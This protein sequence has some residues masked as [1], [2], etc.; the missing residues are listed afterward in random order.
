MGYQL[1]VYQFSRPKVERGDFSHFIRLY[2]PDKLPSGRALRQMMN[3]L[4]FMIEGFDSD[5][6]ELHSIPEVR[7]FYAAFRKAWPYWLFFCNL[8]S[9]ELRMMTLCCLPSIAALSVD[10]QS[11]VVVE[12]D[13]QELL[14]FLRENLILM[15]AMCQRGD[16][17]EKSVHE[18]TRAIF[19]YFGLPANVSAL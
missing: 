11:K 8:D 18:R 7:R 17:L 13:R 19:T 16:V 12:Y 2:H 4:T 14:E 10:Q 3:S 9:E 1:V 5:P 15:S 6:R